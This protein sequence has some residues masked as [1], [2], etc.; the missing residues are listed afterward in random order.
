LLGVVKKIGI[1]NAKDQTKTWAK[2]YSVVE[3]TIITDFKYIKKHYQPSE[4]TEIKVDFS[5]QN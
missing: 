5:L 3:M 1:K 2:H 4:M